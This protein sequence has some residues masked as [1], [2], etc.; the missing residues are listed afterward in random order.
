MVYKY[1]ELILETTIAA[2]RAKDALKEMEKRTAKLIAIET[3][4]N[5]ELRL[6]DCYRFL[7]IASVLSPDNWYY[8]HGVFTPAEVLHSQN[9]QPV[10][11]IGSENKLFPK[12]CMRL[13][14]NKAAVDYTDEPDIQLATVGAPAIGATHLHIHACMKLTELAHATS[15]SRI[16]RDKKK[17][18]ERQSETPLLVKSNY[19]YDRFLHAAEIPF[20]ISA[21]PRVGDMG[22]IGKLAK[23][24]LQSLIDVTRYPKNADPFLGGL[25]DENYKEALRSFNIGRKWLLKLH[26]QERF[27]FLS[28]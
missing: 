22:H 12:L 2:H 1:T 5:L 24:H 16:L 8:Q 14:E 19:R 4:N 25:D 21:C 15:I 9:E 3:S 27:L 28:L 17:P 11:N 10:G 7:I 13:E 6:V 20:I 18:S 23:F 26:Q